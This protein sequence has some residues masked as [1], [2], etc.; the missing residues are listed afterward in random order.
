MVKN[1]SPERDQRKK[2]QTRD[3]RTQGNDLSVRHER[4]VDTKSRLRPH[5]HGNTMRRSLLQA[6]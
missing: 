6:P 1:A 3:Y 2:R 5:R 4:G